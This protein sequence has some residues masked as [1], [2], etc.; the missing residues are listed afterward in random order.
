M[1]SIISLQALRY[2]RKFTSHL[3]T[4][5]KKTEPFTAIDKQNFEFFNRLYSSGIKVETFDIIYHT[6]NKSTNQNCSN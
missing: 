6:L 3:M 5:T 2:M 4:L 1:E